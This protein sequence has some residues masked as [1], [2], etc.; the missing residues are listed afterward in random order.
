MRANRRRD[1]KLETEVRSRLHAR[2]L[3]FRVDFPIPVAGRR[4]IRPDIVFTRR[5][6]CVELDGCWWHGCEVCVQRETSVNRS[7]WGPKIARNKERDREKTAALKAQG[8]TVLRFWGHEDPDAITDAIEAA[9]TKTRMQ[10][11]VGS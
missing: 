7:Y 3:R 10:P 8:W 4:P 2:G 5:R 9:V 11:T 6:I 1:T